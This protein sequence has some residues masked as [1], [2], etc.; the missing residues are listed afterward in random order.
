MIEKPA[1]QSGD[2]GATA[3]SA[4]AID[5][6]SDTELLEAALR[7]AIDAHAAGLLAAPFGVD[8]VALARARQRALRSDM[9]R[10]LADD[11]PDDQGLGDV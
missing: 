8:A 5:A 1:A 6:M 9:R 3:V 4:P 2:D 11:L 10:L 7:D